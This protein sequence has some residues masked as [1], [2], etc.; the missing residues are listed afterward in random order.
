MIAKRRRSWMMALAMTLAASACGG[1]KS[2][3]GTAG[4]SGAGTSGAAGSG[5]GAIATE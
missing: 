5:G 4:A 3:A 1:A 2:G